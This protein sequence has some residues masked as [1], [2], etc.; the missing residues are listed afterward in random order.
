M[1]RKPG[2]LLELKE[3][4]ERSRVKNTRRSKEFC[5]E[6]NK[7][8]RNGSRSVT[9]CLPGT[10]SFTIAT[11]NGCISYF[12]CWTEFFGNSLVFLGHG[13]HISC[14][15]FLVSKVSTREVFPSTMETYECT[16]LKYLP[17]FTQTR[18]LIWNSDHVVPAQQCF[19]ASRNHSL[20]C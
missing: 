10:A 16:P 9:P 5:S 11:L 19:V 12:S 2:R 4:I 8:C 7:A 20:F 3:V 14:T 17:L 1:Y 13:Q 15:K 6:V 18:T